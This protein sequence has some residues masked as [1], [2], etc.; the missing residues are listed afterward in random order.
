M[1]L[2]LGVSFVTRDVTTDG[3]TRATKRLTRLQ[4]GRNPSVVALWQL[5][6][7]SKKLVLRPNSL[8]LPFVNVSECNSK[9]TT[10]E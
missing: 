2:K 4:N 5:A 6:S 9:R 7:L 3:L 10:R 1:E 8:T